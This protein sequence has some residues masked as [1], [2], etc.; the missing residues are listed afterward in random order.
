VVHVEQRSL[1]TL[2]KDVAAA[3]EFITDLGSRIGAEGQ[4]AGRER[5]QAGHDRFGVGP[6]F[7]P[8]VVQD[9]VGRSGPFTY[10]PP[11][12]VLIRQIADAKSVP[13]DLVPVRRADPPPGGPDTG[14]TLGRFFR[15]VELLVIRKHQV[16]TPRH[17]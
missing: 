7:D 5:G 11:A 17:P 10:H 13:G 3:G 15:A 14:V 1:R 9:R 12:V 6:F 2:E 4:D 8:V 16:G